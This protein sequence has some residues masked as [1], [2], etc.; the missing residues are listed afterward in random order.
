LHNSGHFHHTGSSVFA[1]SSHDG[2]RT[3]SR[4]NLVTTEQA[5]DKDMVAGLP[6]GFQALYAVPTGTAAQRASAIMTAHLAAP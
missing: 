3:W 5:S 2:G 6:R 4:S 1:T